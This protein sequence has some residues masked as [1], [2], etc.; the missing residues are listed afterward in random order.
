MA[1]VPMIVSPPSSGTQVDTGTITETGTVKVTLGYQPSFVSVVLFKDSTHFMS[2]TYNSA[3][4][5][6]LNFIGYRSGSNQYAL[7]GT[8]YISSIDADGFT[9]NFAGSVVTAYGTPTYLAVE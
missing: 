1:F 9:V 5:T 4:S 8:S 6:S 2:V 3:L 7:T